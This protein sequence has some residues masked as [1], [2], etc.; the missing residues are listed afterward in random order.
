MQIKSLGFNPHPNHR[1]T[2]LDGAPAVDAHTD[3]SV[4]L[5]TQKALIWHGV[6]PLV[7]AGQVRNDEGANL[8]LHI[9]LTHSQ[10]LWR[11]KLSHIARPILT[12]CQSAV[13]SSALVG[14]FSSPG[15]V[16]T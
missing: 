12:L 10:H 4:P 9:K 1:T 13:A 16:R 14:C 3:G 11:R 5:C 6:S 15:I 2:G 7:T 8:L